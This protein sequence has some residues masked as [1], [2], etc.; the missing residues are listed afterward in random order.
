MK[1]KMH[2]VLM[3]LGGRPLLKGRSGA[4]LRFG[5][6]AMEALTSR[7]AGNGLGFKEKMAVWTVTKKLH[8]AMA[9]NGEVEVTNDERALICAVV[10][11]VFAPM[12]VGPFDE[13]FRKM[14]ASS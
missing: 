6:V 7:E 5:D 14:A 9:A 12:V 2:E 13:C 8:G 11:T 1:V 10:G 4:P 3:G